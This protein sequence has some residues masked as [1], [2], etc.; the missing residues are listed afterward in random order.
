MIGFGLGIS[1][2]AQA[3][4]VDNGPSA[5]FSG[6]TGGF[7]KQG[8]HASITA[9]LSDASTVTAQSWGSTLGGSQYGT[10]TN[11][12]DFSA[13]A[14]GAL[15]YVRLTS[16]GEDYDRAVASYA[17]PSVASAIADQSFTTGDADFTLDLDTVFDDATSYSVSGHAAA[18][19]DGDGTT[20]R[21][22]KTSD[23]SATNITVT[24]TNQL[25]VGEAVTDV[26]S[27]TIAPEVVTPPAPSFAFTV[28]ANGEAI[29][30]NADGDVVLTITSPST[31]ATYDGG[32]GAGTF[33]FNTNDLATGPVVGIPVRFTQA[34][35]SVGDT[36]SVIRAFALYDGA[37]TAPVSTY[38][39]LRNGEP[40]TDIPGLTYEV[41]ASDAGTTL[42]VRQTIEG[43]NGTT[44]S[45]SD[46]IAIAATQA[47]PVLT[48]LGQ[49]QYLSAFT[50]TP[51]TSVDVTGRLAGDVLIF[52]HGSS[53]TSTTATV[54]GNAATKVNSWNFGSG[55]ARRGTLFAHVLQQ[56]D[57]DAGTIPVAFTVPAGNNGPCMVD[58]VASPGK[59]IAGS[60]AFNGA[61]SA[62]VT[63]TQA[64]NGI[65]HF[66]FGDSSVFSGAPL[67]YTDGQTERQ[68]STDFGGFLGGAA[69]MIQNAPVGTNTLTWTVGGTG[70]YSGITVV[71]E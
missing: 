17:A 36:L 45:L 28:D 2:G 71:V 67:A 54:A 3:G 37:N 43:T 14:Q 51:S 7:A 39:I 22:D 5:Q 4:V 46:A 29:M 53:S 50:T 31:Y 23:V 33:A 12:T 61:L 41:S 19:I 58:F 10:G 64:E 70:F 20:L 21:I 52:A 26:F 65:Y 32:L 35:A 9:A 60:T 63:T 48:H 49:Q 11:P 8:D 6:L 30:Q 47:R 1:L 69:G 56:A 62:S 27:L 55:G 24:A 68:F 34:S 15:L 25:G 16:G 44:V 57:I 40:V 42:T 59:A 38:Q 18:V 66:V 13:L